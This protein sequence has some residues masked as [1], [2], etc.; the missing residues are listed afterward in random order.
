MAQSLAMLLYIACFSL[1]SASAQT[2]DTRAP[3]AILIDAATGTIL[4][5]KNANEPVPPASLSKLMTMEVVFNALSEGRLSMDD[6]FF[7]SENAWRRGGANSGGSTMFAELDSSIKLEDLIQGVIVQ[8]GNDACIIIAEGMA[9]S[10]EAFAVLMNRRAS[11]IGLRHSSFTNSTGLP[12]PNH[13][14][15]VRDLAFLSRH[16]IRTYPQFYRFYSQREFTWNNIAQQNRNP[17]LRSVNGADG[18]KTGYTA[19]AG[20]SLAGS[21]VRAGLRL[22]VIVTGLERRRDREEEARKLLDWGFRTFEQVTLF[23]A[24]AEV[25]TARVYGGE[26]WT[27]PLTGDGAIQILLPRE[28]QRQMRAEVSYF[29]PLMPPIAAG[30]EI[31]SLNITTES[32]TSLSVPLYAAEDVEQGP[33]HRRAMDAVLN[34]ISR[35]IHW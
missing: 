4:F 33:L 34:L 16:I 30:D 7:V 32:G 31:A 17:L 8:S 35:H 24:G 5:E 12:D 22:V 29:G 26:T 23:D 15:S 3:H 25:G 10:E 13:L 18:L 2:I 1:V 6:E 27:V 14:M 9:G 28:A 19:E 21:A 20:Y 11:A